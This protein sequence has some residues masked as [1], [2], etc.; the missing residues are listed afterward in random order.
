MFSLDSSGFIPYNMRSLADPRVGPTL[1]ST[2]TTTLPQF[3][4]DFDTFDHLYTHTPEHALDRKTLHEDHQHDL[5]VWSKLSQS[6]PLDPLRV[7]AHGVHTVASPTGSI[8]HKLDAHYDNLG[9]LCT[10]PP[11]DS[12]PNPPPPPSKTLCSNHSP[13]VSRRKSLLTLRPTSPRTPRLRVVCQ[14][15]LA[16]LGKSDLI[17]TFLFNIVYHKSTHTTSRTTLPYSSHTILPHNIVFV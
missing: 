2:L 4:D 10:L 3:H 11:S 16:L 15:K 1:V 6:N 13:Q 17:D 8:L 12:V 9:L 14:R 7:C 5:R